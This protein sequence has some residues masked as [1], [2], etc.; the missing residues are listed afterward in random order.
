MNIT[1]PQLALFA[2]A[3]AV[4]ASAPVQAQAKYP[5]TPV[6]FIVA[7]APGGS[8]DATA[9]II[10]QTLNEKHGYTAIVDNR[11]G[12]GGNLGAEASLREPADG[13]TFFVIL[14]SYSVNAA[15][16]MP[17]FDPQTAIEPVIQFSREPV[18]LAVGMNTPCGDLAWRG[19]VGKGEPA[20]RQ[21]VRRGQP[22]AHR[23]QQAWPARQRLDDAG[24]FPP[25]QVVLS[26]YPQFAWTSRWS[27]F[28][29]QR[30]ISKTQ[31]RKRQRPVATDRPIAPDHEV[32]P[33]ELV[34]HLLEA[35]LDPVA[36]AVQPNYLR[37]RRLL[38]RQ[39]PP[40]FIRL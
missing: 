8:T 13:Y 26:V 31:T 6:K 30:A 37:Q 23:A 35:L 36:Q 5:A 7:F 20:A 39:V 19:R 16:N 24:F 18:V 12:A 9:R 14:S 28:G 3:A 27:R 10:A 21:P 34:F 33:A 4:V 22:G 11:A 1:R 32:G 17:S 2:C 29:R 38:T 40:C 15:L 25:P